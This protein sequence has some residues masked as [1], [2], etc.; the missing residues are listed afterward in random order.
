MATNQRTP[1]TSVAGNS[2]ALMSASARSPVTP[3]RRASLGRLTH[4][5]RGPG[6]RLDF[7]VR[8]VLAA[9]AFHALGPRYLL[10]VRMNEDEAPERIPLRAR[11]GIRGHLTEKLF[12]RRL[13]LAPLRRF[14]GIHYCL[15]S[16]FCGEPASTAG[17]ARGRGGPR[18]TRATCLHPS[19]AEPALGPR[20]CVICPS[21]PAA[22]RVGAVRVPRAQP[23]TPRSAR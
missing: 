22:A 21:P 17:I 8:V 4:L 12:G 1:P 11:A 5:W 15:L 23:P 3:S 2:P 7:T 18:R 19:R 9:S 6:G 10:W 14:A 16:W 13:F 20:R